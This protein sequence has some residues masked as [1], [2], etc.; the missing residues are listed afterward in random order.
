MIFLKYYD[1]LSSKQ[2]CLYFSDAL[3]VITYG[4]TEDQPIFA[5]NGCKRFTKQVPY[6][7]QKHRA[8]S[9]LWLFVNE[10]VIA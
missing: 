4:P 3:S 10:I 9:E 2:F 6:V 5:N 8:K 1:L 7:I